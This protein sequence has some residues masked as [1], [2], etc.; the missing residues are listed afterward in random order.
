MSLR[1]RVIKNIKKRYRDFQPALAQKYLERDGLCLS[2]SIIW[3]I[4]R[5]IKSSKNASHTPLQVHP[6]R[7]RRHRFGE[8]IQIDGSPHRWFGDD[9]P[10]VCLLTFIDDATG[11]ITS[12]RF[13]ETETLLG[14]LTLLIEHIGRYGIPVALYSD[15]HLIF[16]RDVPQNITEEPLQ[17]ARVCQRLR[18]EPILAQMPQAKGRVENLNFHKAYPIF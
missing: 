18:I 12:A 8:L 17:Y 9:G 4:N 5:E 11:K 14:Y 2:R 15:R 13:F 7:W 1:A 6:L 3:R 10:E 16:S